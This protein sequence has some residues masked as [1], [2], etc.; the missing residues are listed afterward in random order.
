[1]EGLRRR[2]VALADVQQ[3]LV[4]A[5][6]RCGELRPVEHEVR[7]EEQQRA[8]LVTERLAFGPVDQ[9]DGSR[10]DGPFRDRAPLAPDRKS[11][12]AA[13]QQPA[14]LELTDEPGAAADLGQAAEALEVLQVWLRPAAQLGPREEA[15]EHRRRGHRQAPRPG[16]ATDA[17]TLR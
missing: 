2:L 1:L 3:D 11:G 14:R 7:A 10:P 17:S 4:G 6:R 9:D 15:G 16:A 13:A 12:P 8:I 5:H